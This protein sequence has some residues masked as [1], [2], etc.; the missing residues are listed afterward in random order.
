MI[1]NLLTSHTFIKLRNVYA[2][3]S[4]MYLTHA[5]YGKNIYYFNLHKPSLLNLLEKGVDIC[6]NNIKKYEKDLTF[7]DCKLTNL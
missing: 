3:Y 1:Y 4:N 6:K 5:R 7:S 2:K